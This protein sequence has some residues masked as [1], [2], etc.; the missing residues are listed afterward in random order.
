MKT[1]MLYL[2]A[3]IL[4]ASSFAFAQTNPDFSGT[5]T[6]NP[7]LSDMGMP[8]LASGQMPMQKIVLILRQTATELS[9][10]R[11][12]PRKETTT[13]KLDGSETVTTLPGGSTS[14]TIMKWV[15]GSLQGT[16]ISKHGDSAVEITDTRSLSPDGKT[17]TLIVNQK[18]PQKTTRQTLVYTKE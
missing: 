1:L 4:G 5:W 11:S 2:V 12:G 13:Y 18:T 16:T 15:D 6:L 7:A 10:E 17:M 14:K 8:K 3:M 9:I